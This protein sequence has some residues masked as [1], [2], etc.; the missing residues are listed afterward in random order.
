MREI[1]R[2]RVRSPTSAD[3]SVRFAVTTRVSSLHYVSSSCSCNVLSLDEQ[4]I[5][6]RIHQYT[7]SWLRCCSG[8]F[9]LRHFLLF[10]PFFFYVIRVFFL[11]CIINLTWQLSCT[12]TRADTTVQKHPTMAVSTLNMTPYFTGYPFQ[13]NYTFFFNYAPSWIFLWIFTRARPNTDST[14]SYRPCTPPEC[15]PLQRRTIPPSHARATPTISPRPNFN[16]TDP[17]LRVS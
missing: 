12:N 15:I 17:C 13:G 6:T 16:N 7:L 4:K 10:F 3:G 11:Y 5:N 8:F 14:M 2:H 9:S 1:P